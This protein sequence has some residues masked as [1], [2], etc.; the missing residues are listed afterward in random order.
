MKYIE[1]E[2]RV[3]SHD[4]F[5]R[6]FEQLDSI[7]FNSAFINWT[8]KL[9]DNTQGRVIATDVKTLRRSSN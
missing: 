7:S 9:S 2:N 6:V 1:L 5:Q 3:L 8:N 4:T